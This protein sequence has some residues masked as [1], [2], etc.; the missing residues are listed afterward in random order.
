MND[1]PRSEVPWEY[2]SHPRRSQK[3]WEIMEIYSMWKKEREG[4][5]VEAS[6]SQEP[7]GRIKVPL[8][9]S[10]VVEV[11]FLTSS[12]VD[13]FCKLNTAKNVQRRPTQWMKPLEKSSWLFF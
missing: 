8:Y 1:D 11:D 4:N 2:F 9:V 10:F 13:R 3:P 6:V 12:P 7:S 5:N